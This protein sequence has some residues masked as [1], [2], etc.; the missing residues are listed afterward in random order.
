ME[1]AKGIFTAIGHQ[2]AQ[3][4]Q[5]N[6]VIIAGDFNAKLQIN[7]N[8]CKQHTSRNGTLLREIMDNNDLTPAN[9]KSNH[10]I[11]TRVNRKN[12]EEKSV[13]DYILTTEQI[14]RNIQS[15]IVDKEGNL[16]I[17]GK[18]ETD[19]NT[20]VMSIRINDPR[21]PTFRKNGTLRTKKDEQ[22]SKK[23]ILEAYNSNNIKVNNYQEAEKE[24][25]K[26]LKKTIRIKKN[27]IRQNQKNNQPRD[28]RSKESNEK[29][30]KGIP[31]IMQNRNDRR[32]NNNQEKLYGQPGETPLRNKQ[33]WIHADRRE[34]KKT[35][36][37][38]H[39]KPKHNMGSQEK[40]ERMQ[41]TWLQHILRGR[42][43]NQRPGKNKRSHSKLLWTTLPSQTRHSTI[44]RMDK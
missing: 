27:K 8:S 16:R 30:R 13:I 35:T 22:N 11:W 24:I 42:H 15:V 10:G 31:E 17:K 36:W 12:A 14:A 26:I 7:S 38:S 37:E 2:I 29:P 1:N 28:K 21:K 18:N 9:L 23:G 5:N 41:G 33:G 34:T 25:K 19:H 39:N 32:Q 3:K 44:R 6:E 40:R 20:I 4:A 43:P